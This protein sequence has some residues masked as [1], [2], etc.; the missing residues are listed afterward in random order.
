MR[1]ALLAC[2]PANLDWL[3]YQVYDVCTVEVFFHMCTEKEKKGGCKGTRLKKSRRWGQRI[4]HTNKKEFTT[5]EDYEALR[6]RQTTTKSL[7][8]FFLTSCTGCLA[9]FTR[10]W[11]TPP[12]RGWQVRRCSWLPVVTLLL[13]L[14]VQK[15]KSSKE[16][17][18]LALLLIVFE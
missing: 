14:L 15:Y 8:F 17:A 6:L 1:M 12:L 5:P 7:M 4:P 18:L 9:S 2:D 3:C 10:P 13:A 11:D 16:V